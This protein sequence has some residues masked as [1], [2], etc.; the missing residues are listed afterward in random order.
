VVF[1]FA[2]TLFTSAFLVFL[3]QPMVGKMILPALGG[4]P[5]VWNT[6]MVFFQAVLLAGYAFAHQSVGWLGPRRQAI[7]QIL[8]LLVPLVLLPIVIDTSSVP[9]SDNPEWWLL[10]RLLLGVGLPFFVVSTNAPLLQMWFSATGHREGKDPYFLYSASNLGSLL[11][12]LGYPVVM[13][14][15]LPLTGQSW[16]W[17]GGYVVLIV[18]AVACAVWMWKSSRSSGC[19]QEADGTRSSPKGGNGVNSSDALSLR[20]SLRWVI[21]AF[22]PSSLMLGLTT[23]VTTDLA[24]VPLLLVVPLALYLL[25]FVWVFAR[26]PP[27]RHGILVWLFPFVIVPTALLTVLGRAGGWLWVLPLHLVAFFLTGLV[28]HGELAADRPPPSR[29]TRF[30][31]LMSVGGVL[32]GFFNAVVAPAVFDTVAEYPLVMVLACLVVGWGGPTGRRSV[33]ETE[34]SAG[35][36][37]RHGGKHQESSAAPKA[38]SV[39]RGRY[40]AYL[41]PLLIGLGATGVKYILFV[42]DAW[43]SEMYVPWIL[44]LTV[45]CLLFR[46]SP[47]RLTMTLGAI[48][49]GLFTYNKTYGRTVLYEGRNFYGTKEVISGREGQ[50]FR[51][52][53]HGNTLHGMQWTDPEHSGLPTTY[54]HPTGP[55]GDAFRACLKQSGPPAQVG[56]IGLGAGAMAAYAMPG[57]HFTFYEIDPEVV[58]I[59]RDP[60]LFTFLQDCRGTTDVVLGDGRLT[61]ARVPDGHYGLLLMDAFSSDA[62]PTHL[63]T[64][65]ALRLYLSK[66]DEHGFIVFNVTNRYVDLPPL[67]ANLARDAGLV[68]RYRIDTN[69]TPEEERLGKFGSQ[70]VVMARRLEDIRVLA[71]DPNWQE[72]PVIEDIGVWTDQYTNIFRLLHLQ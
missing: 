53:Y 16:F 22:I 24:P 30:Y 34:V 4:T 50:T 29:L 7:L 47:V 42:K 41:L 18:L 28:C 8:L 5:A 39:T 58:R 23:Y 9:Q 48:L 25:T 63:L 14:R 71:A 64:R 45:L 27:I 57:Q 13:E 55:V 60:M 40:F 52:F 35:K 33:L 17:A 66:L 1:L 31:L 15:V 49:L 36:A 26:R 21:L 54:F 67:L 2:I 69:I 72:I 59:A 6:C 46:K 44:L 11:A 62:V 20:R 3:V 43:R 32:G 37:G 70:Y 38:R 61:I 19:A 56:I 65:E 10:W 12:L 68:S 51:I